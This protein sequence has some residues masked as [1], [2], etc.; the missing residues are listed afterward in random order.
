MVFSLL[1]RGIRYSGVR[2]GEVS[3]YVQYGVHTP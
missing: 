3:L 2:H 1:Q